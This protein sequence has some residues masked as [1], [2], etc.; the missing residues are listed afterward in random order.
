MRIVWNL[1]HYILIHIGQ[2]VA[3]VFFFHPHFQINV[4]I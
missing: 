2:T 3:V 4:Q 1:L